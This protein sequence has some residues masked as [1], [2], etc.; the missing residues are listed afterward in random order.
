MDQFQKDFF[1]I[2]QAE[3]LPYTASLGPGLVKQGD[4]S[5]PYYFDFISFAQYA[6]IYRDVTVDPPMVFEEQQPV[7]VG[8][9]DKQQFISKIIRRDPTLTNSMLAK[10]HDELVGSMILNRLNEI[11]GETTSAIPNIDSNSS[12]RNAS[13]S[14]QQLTN[15]FLINGFAFEG[16]VELKKEGPNGGISGSQFE[17][18][19][20]S[21]ANLWS[22]QALQLKKA[23]PSN[24]FLLKTVKIF[25]SRAGYEISSSSIKYT[26]SQEIS[27]LTVR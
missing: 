4:L 10:R 3:Y 5:D 25:L 1:F 27:T 9:E 26:S 6:T 21:P 7:I 15:L 11:F 13:A 23:F 17:I 18:K 14:L 8:D 2:R 20:T 16:S 19:L 24:D 22:G 12:A